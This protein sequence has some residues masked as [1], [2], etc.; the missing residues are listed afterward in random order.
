MCGPALGCRDACAA[1]RL[2]VE[3]C[4]PPQ[5]RRLSARLLRRGH[6][7]SVSRRLSRAVPVFPLGSRRSTG[8]AVPGDLRKL[9]VQRPV[10]QRLVQM[11]GRL[12][13]RL[14]LVSIRRA[15]DL[16]GRLRGNLRVPPAD[17]RS[18]H[19]AAPGLCALRVSRDAWRQ[20]SLRRWSQLLSAGCQLRF[21]LSA[22]LS[23][24]V[25]GGCSPAGSNVSCTPGERADCGCDAGLMGFQVCRSS[26]DSYGRCICSPI[27]DAGQPVPEQPIV[28]AGPTTACLSVRVDAVCGAAMPRVDGGLA[29]LACPDNPA[30]FALTCTCSGGRIATSVCDEAAPRLSCEQRCGQSSCVPGATTPDGLCLGNGRGCSNYDCECCSGLCSFHGCRAPCRDVGAMCQRAEDCCSSTCVDGTCRCTSVGNVPAGGCAS[31]G[32]V[33]PGS[34]TRM[35]WRDCCSSICTASGCGCAPSGNYCLHDRDCCAPAVCAEGRCRDC[36]PVGVP[37]NSW[38]D[39]CS[40]LL[41]NGLCVASCTPSCTGKRCG[42]ASGCGVCTACPAGQ[43]CEQLNGSSPRY[44][45][46]GDCVAHS[47]CCASQPTDGGVKNGSWCCRPGAVTTSGQATCGWSPDFVCPTMPTDVCA[48]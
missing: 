41:V 30:G 15:A 6:R 4:L 40:K 22:T 25:L 47:D 14:R 7:R 9:R 34:P 37:A 42:E 33:T 43:R 26:G 3:S 45:C 18:V 27:P 19:A 46:V 31:T 1:H 16:L 44:T 11:Q 12:L 13:S 2:S 39:C 10:L 48:P 20:L 29:S 24:A 17:E 5:P 35:D 36:R 28:D 8:A 38:K 32:L 21:A 23:L